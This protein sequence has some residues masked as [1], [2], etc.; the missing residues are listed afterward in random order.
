MRIKEL[1][2][3]E[4]PREKMLATGPETLS[5]A[6]LLA[7]LIGSGVKG[8]NVLEVAN[9]LL[10]LGE[11]RLGNVAK[12]DPDKMKALSGI[13]P[14]R[15]A[16]IAAAFEL[17]RRCSQELSDVVKLSITDASLVY[18]MM[19]PRMRGLDHE[20]F[21]VIFMNRANYVI[22]KQM[23]SKGGMTS[24]V[25][26]PKIVVRMALEKQATAFIMVHNHPSGNPRPGKNDIEMT[27]QIKKAADTFEIS[28]IDH[29]VVC[30]D[31]Y[32]SF[33]SESVLED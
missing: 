26:D 7:I 10:L 29:I 22:H 13:G 9:R 31:C 20:E 8:A 3:D 5:N 6:E 24:T 25:V 23:I 15:Y 28:L 4:R 2:E 18:R 33:A 27:R 11:G 17:G 12:M 16:C 32:F 1:F 30:D 19:Q 21:W 14:N